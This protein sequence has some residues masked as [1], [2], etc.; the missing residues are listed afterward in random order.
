MQL[1]GPLQEDCVHHAPIAD[2]ERKSKT[3][4]AKMARKT[5]R[6]FGGSSALGDRGDSKCSAAIVFD[7]SRRNL[8]ILNGTWMPQASCGRPQSSQVDDASDMPG[9]LQ[10]CMYVQTLVI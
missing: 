1:L 8:R 7:K 3:R 5:G 10:A 6:R 9:V 2:V 4:R